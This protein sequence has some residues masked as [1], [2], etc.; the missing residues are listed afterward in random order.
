[1]KLNNTLVALALILLAS[2]ASAHEHAV[3]SECTAIA[4]ACEAAHYMPGEHK[5]NGKGMW[6][7]CI[8]A[9]AKGKTVEGVS[10]FSA[11]DAKKCAKAKHASKHHEK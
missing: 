9:I 5:K 4:A 7:D 10:G 1:M 6:A 11:D 2:S 8:H 3:P